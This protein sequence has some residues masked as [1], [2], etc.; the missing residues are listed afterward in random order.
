[1]LPADYR[2]H[3]DVFQAAPAGGSAT[4]DRVFAR[5]VCIEL[6]FLLGPM[7][8]ALFVGL[9]SPAPPCSSPRPAAAPARCCFS[10]R[11]RSAWRIEPRGSAEPLRP[12]A[13][14]G[15]APLLAVIVCYA[16]AFGLI[17]IGTTAYATEVG[18]PRSPAS[19]LAS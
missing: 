2:L 11:R 17:E 4:V 10:A 18:A 6:I 7:L 19:C 3:A 16:L 12:L 13:E 15:F 9:A 14:P 5:I 8:V 1:L